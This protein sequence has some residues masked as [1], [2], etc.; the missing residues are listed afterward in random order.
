MKAKK[1]LAWGM[2]IT[3]ALGTAAPAATVQAA[4]VQESVAAEQQAGAD[5]S[6]EVVAADESEL[7]DLSVIGS[8]DTLA[9]SP[10]TPSGLKG[11]AFSKK[12][13]IY[14]QVNFKDLI[15]GFEYAVYNSN[16]R[17]FLTKKVSAKN[18]KTDS[19][20]KYIYI[21]LQRSKLNDGAFYKVVVRSYVMDGSKKINSKWSSPTYIG[22]KPKNIKMSATSTVQK[23]YISW[24]AMKGATSYSIY[25]STSLKSLGK[26]LA[27]VSGTSYTV[28][29]TNSTIYHYT[30]VANKKVGKKTY[31]A[32]PDTC[33]H[34]TY[35]R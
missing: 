9:A 5:V 14:V 15:D 13:G 18:L 29:N 8:V 35:S 31:K 4:A 26:K 2:A 12:K 23:T 24:S 32:T 33:Y 11:A 25:Q 7:Q 17:K 1:L 6:A 21:P 19:N 28:G 20:R 16:G 22:G 27:T 3:L 10:L 30:I 34:L